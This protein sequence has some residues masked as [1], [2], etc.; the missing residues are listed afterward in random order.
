MTFKSDKIRPLYRN[1]L[2]Y[3]KYGFMIEFYST[4]CREHRLRIF[5]KKKFNRK[6]FE[7]FLKNTLIPRF[8]GPT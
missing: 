5:S 3:G 4:R 6:E 8:V 1:S 2:P 7:T